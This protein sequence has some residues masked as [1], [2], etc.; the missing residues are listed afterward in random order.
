MTYAPREEEEEKVERRRRRAK[1]D[2]GAE[3]VSIG[4]RAL[5]PIDLCARARPSWIIK[6]RGHARL[7]RRVVEL[8]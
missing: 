8:R 6:F 5:L 1:D 4:I 3:I 2:G 7:A